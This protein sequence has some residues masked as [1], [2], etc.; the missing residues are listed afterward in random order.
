MPTPVRLIPAELVPSAPS[1]A[2]A[3]RILRQA[4]SGATVPMWT[5]SA[6][7]GQDGKS[8]NYQMVG[9]DPTTKQ[10]R[11]STRI[12]APVIP[13]IWKIGG[14]SFDP[15]STSCGE[16][17]S[18]LSMVL[19]S[20]VF[21][22]AAFSPG[23]TNVGTTQY[24]DAFQRA[25]FWRYANPSGINPGYH[26][27]LA[28]KSD[29]SVT[30]VVP[31]ADGE[32][33]PTAPS[34]SVGIVQESWAFHYLL[35][36]VYPTL[37]NKTANVKPTAFPIFLFHDTFVVAS[38]PCSPCIGFGGY[39]S[40]FSSSQFAGATQTWAFASFLDPE[41]GLSGDSGTGLLSHEVGEWMDDPLGLDTTP[42]WGHIGQVTGCQ[43]NLEVGDPLTG[44][45]VSVTVKGVGYQ[46]QD[47]AFLPWF[48]GLSPSTSANGWYSFDDSLSSAAQSC[49]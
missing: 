35:T 17:S 45:Q 5:G 47:L 32:V 1:A 21:K 7:A 12:V 42:A 2:D 38:V 33:L 3:A 9:T 22:K 13:I 11:P 30:V 15:T 25:N 37:T 29:K 34:C 8:Y 16:T 24:L 39:H 44:H 27:L 14:A 40:F 10:A 48:Y 4:A 43:S 41:A 28:P 20:P 23:G 19:S 46:L 26:V 18:A 49:H 31:A 36:K 6:T